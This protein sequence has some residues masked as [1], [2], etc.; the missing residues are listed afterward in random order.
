MK[1][2]LSKKAKIVIFAALALVICAAAGF[3]FFKA[4]T[5][6]EQ[7]RR[8]AHAVSFMWP[9]VDFDT[10]V[11][12]AAYI[13]YGRVTDISK[14]Q[15]HEVIASDGEPF[16]EYHRHIT[17]EVISQ[18]K[19]ENTDST[20]LY[21]EMAGE[22]DDEIL[23]VEGYENVSL[24]EEILLFANEHGAFLS[25]ATIMPVVDGVIDPAD[26]MRPE[27]I[28]SM[29]SGEINVFDYLYAVEEKL[30]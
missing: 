18:L 19:G 9:Y 25:P 12:E 13:V 4:K 29:R 10:A 24:D 30:E 2:A 3:A 28:S 7:P 8:I 15:L 26:S 5:P 20:V 27:N 23:I 22:S 14:P 1:A 11:E 17:I 21:R 6:A 16:R